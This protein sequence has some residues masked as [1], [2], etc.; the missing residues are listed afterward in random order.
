MENILVDVRIEGV[1]V[2]SCLDIGNDSGNDFVLILGIILYGVLIWI[3]Y[4][5]SG[6]YLI[7]IIGMILQGYIN[8]KV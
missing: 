2:R 1:L 3:L 7:L 6:N 5:Y 4:L 8:E